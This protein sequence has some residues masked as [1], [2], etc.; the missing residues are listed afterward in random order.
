V[1]T[2]PRDGRLL[3]GV[4]FI[5]EGTRTQ[6]MVVTL[7]ERQERFVDTVTL[8]KRPDVKARFA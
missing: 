6:S 8:D 3:R 7:D 5:G 4:R 2:H 1:G